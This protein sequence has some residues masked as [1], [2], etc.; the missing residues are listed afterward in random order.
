[1]RP[2]RKPRLPQTPNRIQLPDAGAQRT[3]RMNSMQTTAIP[4]AAN[5]AGGWI[6]S[7]RRTFADH[8]PLYLCAL[9]FCGL[10]FAIAAAYHVPLAFDEGMIV[11]LT[12]ALSL[13]A[14]VVV[15]ALAVGGIG[16]FIDA[17]RD[18]HAQPFRTVR[19]WAAGK[20]TGGERPG[21]VFHTILAFVPL[22][23]TFDALKEVITRINPF[24]WDMTFSHWDRVL[25]MGRLPW[26]RLQ[27]FLGHQLITVALNFAYDFWFL[28]ILLSLVWEAFSP[29]RDR[30]RT[31]YLLAFAF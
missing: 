22:L 3:L 30:I 14:F 31:Q 17:M 11:A 4:V 26:E 6:A 7:I 25:G 19:D 29:R 2:M 23:V 13:M 27:P 18:G 9:L 12:A 5:E 10:T 1:M 15:A 16:C 28:I 21:N 8:V 24:S 20:L